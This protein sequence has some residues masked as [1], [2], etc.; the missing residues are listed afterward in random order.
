MLPNMRPQVRF[1]G[2]H[3]GRFLVKEH[4]ALPG[5]RELPHCGEPTRSVVEGINFG[6]DWV[7]KSLSDPLGL[8]LGHGAKH[9]RAFHANCLLSL[10][11]VLPPSPHEYGWI[12]P[13]NDNSPYLV[14]PPCHRA[15]LLVRWF[16]LPCGHSRRPP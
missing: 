2:F 1:C 11:H 4:L 6:E 8:E 10:S 16:G 3:A 9:H 14:S 7:K 5:V 13:T 12:L 15:S